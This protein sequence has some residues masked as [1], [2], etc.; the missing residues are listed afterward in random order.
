MLRKLTEKDDAGLLSVELFL[1]QFQEGD[2]YE[3][4]LEIRRVAKR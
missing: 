4:A 1:P 2:P 3:V